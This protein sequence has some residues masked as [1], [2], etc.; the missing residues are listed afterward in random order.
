M[1][2][3]IENHCSAPH[4]SHINVLPVNKLFSYW[5]AVLLIFS[6]FVLHTSLDGPELAA[7]PKPARGRKK[8][9]ES[10][11]TSGPAAP[12]SKP[13]ASSSKRKGRDRADSLESASD[14]VEDPYAEIYDGTKKSRTSKTNTSTSPSK[15]KSKGKGKESAPKRAASS[16][17]YIPKARSGGHGILIALY[18][19][20]S[21]D[22]VEDGGDLYLTKSEIIS[23]AQ[24]FCDNDYTQGSLASSSGAGPSSLTGSRGGGSGGGNFS[25]P[26]PKSFFTAW[27]NMKTLIEKGYVYQTGNPPKFCLT[28]EGFEVA[29]E[30]ANAEGVR[31]PVDFAD[32]RG[33][34]E[35]SLLND[36]GV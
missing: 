23:E 33:A 30:L 27:T 24:P 29:R 7:L 1:D 15:S 25:G 35:E 11:T 26:N 18:L 2:I 22:S 17:R 12:K 3:Q 19:H 10:A 13:S 14:G 32:E 16:K 34:F 20:T 36:L 21:G 31:R 4:L 5:N 6:S 9:S 8:A 28:Q